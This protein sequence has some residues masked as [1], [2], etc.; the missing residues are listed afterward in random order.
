MGASGTLLRMSNE[1]SSPLAEPIAL[2]GVGEMGGVFARAFLRAGHPVT[3]VLRN[4][5]ITAVARALPDPALALITVAEGDLEGVLAS[6]PD[7]WRS[8]AGLLQ[9]ELL[10]ATWEAHDL[11]DPTVASVWFEKKAGRAVKVIIPTP[12]AGPAASI[13]VTALDAIGIPARRVDHGSELLDELLAKNAYI[14]TANIA[15]LRTGGTVGELW[16]THHDFAA[17]VAD[18]VLDVQQALVGG[19]IDRDAAIAGMVRAFD[20]DPDHG[21]TG[22]SAPA[23]LRRAVSQADAAGLAV[24]LLREILAEHEP[25]PA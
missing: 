12:V 15:G 9:N 5:D 1:S 6:L 3:P 22:R 25:N 18:E 16:S 13:V 4:S 19:P 24:P 14:L 17:A 11:D 20:G 2:I 10:P 21:T 7:T 23:R 8:R